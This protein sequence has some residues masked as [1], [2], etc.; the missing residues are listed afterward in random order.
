MRIGYFI[1]NFP[2]KDRLDDNNYFKKYHHGGAEIAAYHLA[3]EM[4]KRGHDINVFSTSINSKSSIEKYGNIEIYRY[5]TNFRVLTSNVSFGMLRGPLRHDVDV[6]HTHF[7]IAPGP[8]VGLRYAKKKGIPLIIT[9]H[10]DWVESF[11]CFIRRIGVAINNKFLVDKVLSYANVIISPS[12]FYI[13]QS[14]FLG[15]YLDKIVVIPNGVNIADFDIPHSK[16]ECRKKL[17]LTVSSNIILF[18]G[19]LTPYK[20]PDIL[21]RAM[22]NIIKEVPDTMLILVG[23]GKMQNELERLAKR[24]KVDKQIKLAGFVEERLKYLYYRAADVFCLP[25]TMSTEVF[26]VVLLEASASGLPMVVSDLDTFRCII[27]EEY[28]GLFTTRRDENDLAD[29]IIHL[30]ENEEVRE[31]MGKNARRKVEDYSWERIAEETERVYN[32]VIG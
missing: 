9:Y 2:Y 28:N 20:G 30:L 4:A 25:S 31:K 22:T 19:S 1:T 32:E 16:E 23:S 21:V 12:E 15:K 17:G 7:D 13:M 18:V 11:G 3:I 26:P 5:G 29:A 8:L 24:L 6:I 27:E 10:G 14:R